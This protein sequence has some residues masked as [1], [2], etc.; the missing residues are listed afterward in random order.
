MLYLITDAEHGIKLRYVLWENIF[1]LVC[2]SFVFWSFMK[3]D[4]MEVDQVRMLQN[5][6]IYYYIHVIS[7][8]I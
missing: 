1:S 3:T 2:N 5:V 6:I 4:K 7:L 8:F